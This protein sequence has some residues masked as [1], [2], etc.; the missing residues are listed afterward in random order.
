MT[1]K[2]SAIE[3]GKSCEDLFKA[4]CKELK[5]DKILDKLEKILA[6]HQ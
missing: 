1:L 2:E 5:F 3:F 6:N 4:L